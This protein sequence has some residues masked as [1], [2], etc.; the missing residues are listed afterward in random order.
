MMPRKSLQQRVEQY[1]VDVLPSGCRVWLGHVDSDGYGIACMKMEDGLKNRRVHRLVYADR[2]GPIPSGMM[3]C[4]KCDIP[5]CINPDHLFL[6]S[7][8]D[9]NLDKGKKGRA[10]PGPRD[11]S[12]TKNPNCKLS[13]IQVQEIRQRH[14][15]GARTGLNS[16]ASLAREF[17]VNRTQIQKITRGQQW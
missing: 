2:H 1:A 8:A 9:N 14:S 12:R 13:E 3:V 5:S 4:H 15:F 7:A 17:G 16:T 11:N 6:G 10:I